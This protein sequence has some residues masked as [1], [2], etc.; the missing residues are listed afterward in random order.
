MPCR[1]IM[2]TARDGV[3]FGG[4]FDAQDTASELELRSRFIFRGILCDLR[5]DKGV[6][7]IRSA[8]EQLLYLGRLV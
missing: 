4:A 8:Q 7:A 3:F 5:V 1:M 2:A 6:L